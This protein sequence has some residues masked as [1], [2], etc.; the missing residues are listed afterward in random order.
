MRVLII[1]FGHLGY[2]HAQGVQKYLRSSKGLL[3]I[4]VS[5]TCIIVASKIIF[6]NHSENT[7]ILISNWF[8][9]YY[10]E[11]FG[12]FLDYLHAYAETNQDHNFL[13]FHKFYRRTVLEGLCPN[14]N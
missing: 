10:K 2:R 13:L 14:L 11:D 5:T 3:D 7:L 1:G 9:I 8:H 12:V 6:T 4:L